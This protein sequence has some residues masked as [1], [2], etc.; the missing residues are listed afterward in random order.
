MLPCSSRL[1]DINEMHI[2]F[3]IIPLSAFTLATNIIASRRAL[4]GSD[5]EENQDELDHDSSAHTEASDDV[6]VVEQRS[7]GEEVKEEEA[8]ADVMCEWRISVWWEMYISFS[9]AYS[10]GFDPLPPTAVYI[11]DGVYGSFNCIMFDHQIVHPYPLTVSHSTSLA[12]PRLPG[13]PPAN[14]NLPIDLTLSMGYSSAESEI[15]S[16]WG[17]TCDSIDCV[18]TTVSL[19]KGLKTGD[20]LGW[21]EM[22]AYTLCAASRFNG[23]ELSEVKWTTGMKGGM[24]TQWDG[25]E[26]R[27]ILDG[28]KI[29]QGRVE[30]MKETKLIENTNE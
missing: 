5:D 18:R 26:V 6:V 2:H 15:A 19:P 30:G 9:V 25:Q 22:G 20:W 16:I 27:R 8:G 12:L 21:G 10:I 11:N 13:P 24:G 7:G 29:G 1:A 14:I 4:S 17:P 23:F 28:F 3:L